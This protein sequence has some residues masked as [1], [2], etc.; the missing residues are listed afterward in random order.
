ML[1]N[2]PANTIYRPFL[3]KAAKLAVFK[4]PMTKLTLVEDLAMG[5]M[6]LIMMIHPPGL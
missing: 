4:L 3:A 1:K 2:H 6:A 5:I